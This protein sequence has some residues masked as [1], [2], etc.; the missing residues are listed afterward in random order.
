MYSTRKF[1]RLLVIIV[2]IILLAGKVPWNTLKAKLGFPR[3]GY[4]KYR[5]GE[6]VQDAVDWIEKGIRNWGR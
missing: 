1:W 2:F 4:V 3:T 6:A 5:I